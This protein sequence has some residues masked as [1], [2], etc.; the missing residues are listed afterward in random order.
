[1]SSKI[2][3]LGA[4]MVGKA[5]AIDLAK[6]HEV[7]SADVSQESL[8]YLK[9]NYKIKTLK[10]DLRKTEDLAALVKDYDLVVCA[11][12]GF[13][14]FETI[15]AVIKAGKNIVDISFHPEDSLELDSLAKEVGVT[16][17]TDIGVAPG[18]PNILAGYYSQKMKITD[19]EYMVGGLPKARKFPFEYKAPFSP[20]DV[21]EEYTRPA[22]YVENN[23]MVTKPAMS[24]PELLHFDQ[25]GTLEAFN[26]DGLR[27]LIK[28]LPN[29]PNMKEKTLRFPGHIKLIQALQTVGFMSHEEI[30]VKGTKI[31]PFDFTS[32]LLFKEWKLGAEEPE[33]TIM[34]IKI[35]GTDLESGK[36]KEIVYDLY[37]EYDP[38]EK[39]SSMARTTGF[40]A[41]AGVEL[42]LSGQFTEVGLFPPELV[43]KHEK[44][45]HSVLR[46]L[47]DRNIVMK[48]VETDL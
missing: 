22:R 35:T 16:V 44:C 39:L 46:H 34:R 6:K 5:I 26:T 18:V 24:D 48:R 37:D 15:K 11:V 45:Y 36:K 43:G 27:S 20:C 2:I 29:I 32:K 7:T 10:A 13:M 19:F 17:M 40:T 8:D 14:G 38:R 4:G 41:T 31:K 30:D 47:K 25:V 23:V 12:P 28:T 3:V 42:F 1:M 33:F 21:I 9:N